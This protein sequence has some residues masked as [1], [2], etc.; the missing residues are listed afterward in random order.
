MLLW[1]RWFK[2]TIAWLLFSLAVS[3][4][5]ILVASLQAI[6]ET[7]HSQSVHAEQLLQQG[8]Q[9]YWNREYESAKQSWEKALVTYQAMHN[10]SGEAWAL[11]YLGLAYFAL[12]QYDKATIAYEQALPIFR[13]L[14]QRNGEAQALKDLG[15]AY[16][17][18]FDYAK[19]I[20]LYQQALP[21]FRSIKDRNQE[22][23]TLQ[24]LGFTYRSLA[25]YDKAINFYQ[26]ALPIFRTLKN[27]FGEA[28][29]LKDLGFTYFSQSK[30][31]KSLSLYQQALPLF[32]KVKDPNGEAYTIVEMGLA[33]SSLLQYDKAITFYKQSL[34]I[35]QQIKDR[36][37][38][39]HALMNWGNAYRSQ[40]QYDKAIN[41]YQRALPIFREAGDREGE[42]LL[43][44]NMGQAYKRLQRPADAA[45]NLFS[46]IQTFESLS[47]GLTD[48]DKVSFFDKNLNVYRYLEQVLIGLN[49]AEQAL[50]VTERGRAR[51]FAELL[52]SKLTKTAN[53]VAPDKLLT[54][55][56]I[57]QIAKEQKATLVEYSIANL[58]DTSELLIWVIKPTGEMAFKSVNLRTLKTSLSELVTIS[59]EAIG[60]R[61]RGPSIEISSEPDTQQQTQRLRQLYDLLIEPISAYLPSNDSSSRV[62]FMPQGELFL[63]PFPALQDAGGRYLI[64][65]YAIRTAPSIQVLQLT[66]EQRQRLGQQSGAALVMGNPTMPKVTV[67]IG[68]PPEQLQ[69][70]SGAKQ[71]AL[72]I[73]QLLNTQAITGSEATK[74]NVLPK[75]TQARFVHLATH[76][77]LD[78]FKGLG[79]PGAIAL[80]PSGT[81]E[82]NDGLLT[83]S[84]ILDMKF[85]AELV[86]LSAC[87]T[88]RGRVTGDGVIGL[89]RSLIAAG[90]PSVLV[91]LWSVPDASTA[92]LMTE[93]YRN[94]QEKKLD[95][96]QALQ[97]AM[98]AT[99]KQYPN[100]RSW[101]AFTL[102]G[103]A[104]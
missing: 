65:K 40:L 53:K 19:A 23:L 28:Y 32:R 87:D 43:F 39:A 86:V 8:K 7:T 15:Q 31:D 4:S 85:N 41:L 18:K 60:V 61:S 20:N 6:A 27:P 50:E 94:M 1:S 45:E 48:S 37:G 64:E 22:A 56:Q 46:A 100:P 77:L 54:L 16:S 93:F 96:A 12:A 35:F 21:I 75:L 3:S 66:H 62:I 10:R 89:S 59:R 24:Y 47:P 58:E 63:V 101:A 55:Q 17:F 95:K 88:G 83:A 52:A 44:S 57:Q 38:E 81:G 104:E 76:G 36:K 33:Y 74:A 78:D 29:A 91:S 99:M 73:A 11:E 103:E 90:V 69:D 34:S 82:L 30:Y 67:K 13:E 79:V 26:E 97:Q 70:L 72:A 5:A 51:A 71:E 92:E 42:G 102:I 68:T 80:A 14:K 49:H 25:Q 9:Q 2:Y 84:E 98:L